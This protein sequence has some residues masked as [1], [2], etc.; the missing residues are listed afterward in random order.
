MIINT[1]GMPMTADTL[2]TFAKLRDGSWGLRIVNDSYCP[3]AGEYVRVTRRDGEAAF[4]R[5]G[6]VV[7]RDK[8]V[9]LCTIGESA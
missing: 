9:A 4:K 7:W 6:R 5:V 8:G 2:A 1:E 3:K